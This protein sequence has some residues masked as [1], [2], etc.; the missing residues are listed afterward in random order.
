M[1]S[2]PGAESV[3]PHLPRLLALA[4]DACVGGVVVFDEI[5]SV[6]YASSSARSMLASLGVP[7]ASRR[8]VLRPILEAR[9]AKVVPLKAASG[10]ICG[11]VV[12]IPDGTRVTTLADRERR[13]IVETLEATRWRLSETARRL[14]ISRTTLWRRVRAYGLAR[15]A[16]PARC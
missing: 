6:V 9:G 3:G 5:G 16:D 11:E 4:L 2:L 10:A 15:E 14:G 12:S 1:A 13:A 8:E 7:A